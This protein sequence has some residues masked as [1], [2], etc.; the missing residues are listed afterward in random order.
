MKVL[1]ISKTMAVRTYRGRLHELSKLG[2]DL[3]V[4]VPPRW[5]TRRVETGSPDGY[6]L[7]VT[8]ARFTGP[9]LKRH[10]NHL[11]YYPDV[12]RVI[13]RENW[14]LIHVDEE[15]FNF[16][17]YHSLRSLQGNGRP[18]VFTTWQNL[19]KWYPPPFSTF[20]RSVFERASGAICGNAQTLDVLR[21]RGFTKPAVVIPVHG[22][23]PRIYRK[24]R[25]T[26]LREKLGLEGT[27]AVGF[28]GRFSLEKSLDT[29]MKALAL[30]SGDS[31]LVLLGAGPERSRLE[32]KT[33]ELGIAQRVRWM[34]WVN[35]ADV[36]QYMNA[37]DV[38]VLPSRTL[39][40][41]REQFGRVLIE[42]MAC[43][44]CVVGS[45][46]GEIP[47]VIGDAGLVFHE[48]DEHELAERLKRLMDDST[49]RDSL[50]RRGRERVL[51]NFTHEKIAR[52]TVSFYERVCGSRE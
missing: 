9:L 40:N 33:Q 11:H 23:D 28:I 20:E 19:M 3:T 22:V 10:S 37:F 52:D 27:F 34:P 8:K 29:L 42:A 30:L 44:T 21:R 49:L 25:A 50:G 13:G 32:R 36:P 48:G 24:Q 5:G 1:V 2:V 31:V 43:E 38:L 45:D 4:I 14:D 39:P 41:I 26:S 18:V 15:P 6:E 51:E 12:A 16:V 17:T 35:S 7:I 47:K 46:S